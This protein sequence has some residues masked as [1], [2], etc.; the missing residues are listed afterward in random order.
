MF[1]LAGKFASRFGWG[2]TYE[3]ILFIMLLHPYMMKRTETREIATQT[4]ED[5]V[6]PINRMKINKGT[7]RILLVTI[8]F[9]VFITTVCT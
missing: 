5:I 8:L 7:T 3:T 2:W 4:G 1:V 9:M 6:L